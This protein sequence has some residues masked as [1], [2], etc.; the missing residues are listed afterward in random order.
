MIRLNINPTPNDPEDRP[1]NMPYE[2]RDARGFTLWHPDDFLAE[3]DE[4]L[5]RVERSL[6]ANKA[7]DWRVFVKVTVPLVT[8]A[9][10]A[11]G[12]GETYDIEVPSDADP[13]VP[14]LLT[15]FKYYTYFPVQRSL[16]D[17]IALPA[18]HA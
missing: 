6:A 12:V 15:Y 9:P 18:D 13:S 11:K 4:L 10:L 5:R 2:Q 16:R 7:R 1:H 17:S 3:Y 8:I 14:E